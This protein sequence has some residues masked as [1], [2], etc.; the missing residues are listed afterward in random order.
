MIGRETQNIYTRR[1]LKRM[2]ITVLID[3]GA[4]PQSGAEALYVITPAS[5][6]A[7]QTAAATAV[8]TYGS[9]IELESEKEGKT[10]KGVYSLSK[11][12]AVF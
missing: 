7:F 4:A 12:R 11:I 6:G 2:A 10:Q 9:F 5:R 3:T 1:R 8:S